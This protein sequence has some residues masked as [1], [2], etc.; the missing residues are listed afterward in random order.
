[1]VTHRFESISGKSDQHENLAVQAL[2][3]CVSVVK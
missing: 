1:M 2:C 3:L